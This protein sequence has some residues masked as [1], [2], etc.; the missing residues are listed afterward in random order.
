MLLSG[1]GIMFRV[2]RN[3]D[4]MLNDSHCFRGIAFDGCWFYLTVMDEN[5]IIKCNM[6]FE[7]I[8][9]FITC[10]CY[11]YI[12]YDFNEDCFWATDSEG[13]SCVFKLNGLFEEID[14]LNILVPGVRDRNITG[15]SYNY[16]SD[17]LYL[18]FSNA[19]VCI[20][21][22][23]LQDCRMLF[24]CN[25]KRIRGITGIFSSF[26]TFG[27]AR[28]RKEIRIIHSCGRCIKRISVPSCLRVE[29]I[30]SIP[31]RKDNSIFHFFVLF[32][33]RNGRQCV[34]EF[35]VVDCRL[36][37]HNR[38]CTKALEAIAC[39]EVKIANCLIEES[40]RLFQIMQTSNDAH[41][42]NEAK[43]ALC[44]LIR[45]A[46]KREFEIVEKLQKLMECCDFCRNIENCEDEV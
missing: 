18:S 15:I 24:C 10:R 6:D 43:K 16:C 20:N 12:C 37:E 45:R 11:T 39:D 3:K 44:R 32:T 23:C 8:D 21:K 40:E 41:E 35:I 22:H 2:E 17:R 19:I 9:C 46:T 38:C 42:I 31:C 5:K 25:K 28:P 36:H 4:F 14:I 34:K 33:K 1:V 7:E 30:F 26:I 27:I 29:S 13:E